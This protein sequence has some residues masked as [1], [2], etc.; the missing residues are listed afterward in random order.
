ME[1]TQVHCILHQP[2]LFANA[3]IQVSGSIASV[4]TTVK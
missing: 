4:S 1:T 3:C 2:H